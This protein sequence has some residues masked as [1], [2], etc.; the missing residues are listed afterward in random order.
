MSNCRTCHDNQRIAQPAQRLAA[1][2]EAWKTR[3][4]AQTCNTCHAVD[5]T[6]HFG[7]QTNNTNCDVCHNRARAS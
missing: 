6:T 5:F 3:L 7:G 4:S 1:D 2:A